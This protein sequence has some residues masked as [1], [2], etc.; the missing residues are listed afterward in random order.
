MGKQSSY[1]YCVQCGHTEMKWLGKCPVCQAWNTLEKYHQPVNARQ[2]TGLPGSFSRGVPH[3]LSPADHQTPQVTY[4]NNIDSSEENRMLTGIEEFDRVLGGGLI[5]GS[6]VL[7]GGDPGI[8]K[9]TL[10]LQISAQLGKKKYSVLYLTGEESLAQ[11]KMRWNRL[12]LP[13]VDV[14]FAAVTSTSEIDG[15]LAENVPDLMIVDSIQSLHNPE[16]SSLPG[17]VSQLKECALYL[18]EVAKKSHA[19]CFMVGHVTK[20]GQIAGPKVLE[21]IVD[22]VIYF[23]GDEFHSYRL[24]R[25]MKNRFG[26]L[27]IG[28]F[29]MGEKG[30]AQVTNP[31]EIFLKERPEPLIGSTILPTREGTRVFLVEIQALV[32]DSHLGTPRRVVTGIDQQRVN[33]ITAVIEKKAG[34]N[35]MGQDVFINAAG[36]VKVIEPAADL[37][38]AAA[39]VSSFKNTQLPKDMV[40]MGEIGLTGEIRGCQQ[41]ET[42]LREAERMGFSRALIPGNERGSSV[43]GTVK[44]HLIPVINLQEALEAIFNR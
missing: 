6:V 28:V 19:A 5:P 21:H 2:S 24:L 3:N 15:L 33:M 1:Y 35:L 38:V 44:I 16:V 43:L 25:G 23:E 14:L 34:L 12:N 11:V 26:S 17:S 9:S 27:E 18:H 29:E 4:I 40:V 7:V 30:L 37:A 13:A 20:E 32:S 8:G 41:L 39:L 31:S 10:M 22:T 42:R 36:G